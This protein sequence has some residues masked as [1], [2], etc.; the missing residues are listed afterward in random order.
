MSDGQGLVK[1]GSTELSQP[2]DDL[3]KQLEGYLTRVGLPIENVVVP[4][5]ERKKVI[6]SLE[7]SLAII[8]LEDRLRSHYLSKYTV[9]IS[10]GLFDGALNYLWDETV[11]AFRRLII[12]FD[13][14]YFYSIAEKISSRYKSLSKE[15]DIDQ[16]SEHDLLEAC[17]RIGLLSDVNYQRLEHVN[18]MRNHASA[19]HPNDNDI[20][21]HEM[22]GWLSVCLRHAITAKPDHSLITVKQLLTNIRSTLIPKSDFSVI[23]S[24]F[25]K[26]PIE[27]I[28][29]LLWTV[30]G[31]YTTDKT[32]AETKQ[33]IAGI[34]PYIW[35]AATED[36]KYEIGAKFGVFRKNAD[37]QRK[38]ACQEFLQHVNG[39]NYKDED[40]LAGEIIE[41][42]ENL[43][44]AHFG[45]NNFYNEYP[46]A[47]ALD[48]SLPPNGVVPRAAR[49][50]WVKVISICFI[51][52]GYG[53]RNGVDESAV[54]YY[55][56][57]INNFTESEIVEFIRLFGDPEFTSPLMRRMPDSRVRE[58]AKHL[59]TKTTNAHIIKS[60]D[61]IINTPAMTTHK[62]YA[63]TVFKNS[64]EY[65]P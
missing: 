58:Q 6:A 42:L 16:V 54:P 29:D 33:N 39:L 35:N 1:V 12:A 17:R 47:K 55:A 34:A 46:H 32:T 20:D 24:D 18:Y 10:V 65:L 63:A 5:S 31:L 41:K 49:S 15:E 21:G 27:R 3:H 36:R 30:F 13:L 53:Y 44:R 51:G 61:L 9:A 8:P 26:Q 45:A 60:L 50:M 38:D 4:I 28:D 7:E 62:I 22:L 64:L 56:K 19:A 52:N 40:S 25:I 43:K 57:H 11:R 48:D 23:G 37:V 14:Q 59:K 2:I